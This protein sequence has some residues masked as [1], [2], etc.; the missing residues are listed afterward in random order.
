M[1]ML[2][3]LLEAPNPEGAP[4]ELEAAAAWRP[5]KVKKRVAQILHRMIQ[6]YGNPSRTP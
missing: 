4:A 2:I 1:G 6:R 5:W 3:R